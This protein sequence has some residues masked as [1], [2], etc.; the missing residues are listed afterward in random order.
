[1]YFLLQQGAKSECF[2]HRPISLP[3]FQHCP[4]ALKDPLQSYMGGNDGIVTGYGAHL[5]GGHTVQQGLQ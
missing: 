3:S 2:S 4:A 5:V 1:V